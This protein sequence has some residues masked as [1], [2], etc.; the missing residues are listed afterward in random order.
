LLA[1]EDHTDTKDLTAHTPATPR[2]ATTLVDT[3]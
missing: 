3:D 2:H 1:N